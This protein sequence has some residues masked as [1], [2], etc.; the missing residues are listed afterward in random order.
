MKIRIAPAAFCAVAMMILI[1]EGK[2]AYSSAQAGIEL[3]LK[4][5]IPSLFPFF[6]LSGVISSTLLG[7]RI[8][9]LRP[10]GKICRIPPG[11]ES[12]LL[13]GMIGGYPV[14][15]QMISNA[16]QSG[17]L[18]NRDSRRMLGFC[19][20]AGP[21][22]LFGMLSP[23]FRDKW[24]LW[25][26]WAVHIA[27]ALITGCIL[28]GENAVDAKIPTGTPL[29]ISDSLGKAVKTMGLVC[30]WVVA[31]RV[32]LGFL[33]RWL[34]GMLPMAMRILISGILEL[35]NGC[36]LLSQLPDEGLRFV[37]AGLF[38]SLGGLCVFMQTK[39]VT[40]TTGI[41]WYL[42]GKLLQSLISLFLCLV[43]QSCIFTGSSQLSF[44]S[45]PIGL[46]VILCTF[47]IRK[48]LGMEKTE[49]MLY[50]TE[51]TSEKETGYAISQGC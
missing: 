45:I 3:C 29:T 7:S 40:A 39:S 49:K 46:A 2:T 31:F 6:I 43:L 48:K 26:L 17:N 27:S 19:C 14:G 51:N 10:I 42:H 25:V 38:L 41:G 37:F 35:S 5:V 4:A 24:I 21:A 44:L 47:G 28:P 30:G 23:L 34:F 32:L 9:I 13:L 18:S 33:D 50:N 16:T 15:A 1:L 12:L 20:N 11:S 22:F 8:K 36:L